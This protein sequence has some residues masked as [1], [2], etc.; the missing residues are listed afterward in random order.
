MTM[1]NHNDK[2]KQRVSRHNQRFTI[3]ISRDDFQEDIER[4][5]EKWQIDPDKL[6]T[7]EEHQAWWLSHYKNADDWDRDNWSRYRKE[8]VDLEK[9][10]LD[11]D[12][13]EVTY[14]QF[15]DREKAVND[16]RIINA[17]FKDLRGIVAK[18]KLPP[19]WEHAVRQY[20]FSN[21]PKYRG[22]IGVTISAPFSSNDDVE[23]DIV[24]IKLDAYTTK[25]DL[26][27]AWPD[28]KF[29]LDKLRHKQHEKFQPIDEKVLERNSKAYTLK[30]QGKKYEEIAT[31]LSEQY[32]K[33]FSY[34]DVSTM[35]RNYKKLS[36]IN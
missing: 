15:K 17:Y 22:F 11:R 27:D 35:I 12:N 24:T 7:N 25:K 29:H 32:D 21:E 30:K 4:F 13:K 8:L 14:R 10:A 3:L 28:I 5:R 19:K 34:E 31:I 18:Y 16:M 20:I 36:G 26:M 33:A 1:K 2:H 23:K 9:A 6:K